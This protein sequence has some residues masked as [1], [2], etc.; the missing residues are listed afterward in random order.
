MTMMDS[1]EYRK[2]KHRHAPLNPELSTALHKIPVEWNNTQTDFPQDATTIHQL[3]EA[4]AEKTPTAIALVYQNQSL[5]YYELNQK[6]NQLAHFLQKRGVGPEVPVG[7]CLDRSVE[8]VISLLG[9]LKAGGA[10]I[11]LDPNYPP[12]RLILM[13]ADSAS[14]LLLTQAHLL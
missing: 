2:Q 5:S 1:T 13:M 8:M 6:A 11:P 7:I 14:P 12:D 10:Y 3:F 4:Q 9:I